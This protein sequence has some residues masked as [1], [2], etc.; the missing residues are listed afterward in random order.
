MSF[1]GLSESKLYKPSIEHDQRCVIVS[2][3]FYE[4][5]RPEK[6]A[7]SGSG[8]KQ[9]YLVYA[10]QEENC[11]DEDDNKKTNSFMAFTALVSNT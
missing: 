11:E 6:K 8:T 9:P 5:Q 2:D 4:W 10:K 7:G 3:G 1:S